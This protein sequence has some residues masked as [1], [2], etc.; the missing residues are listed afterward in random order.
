MLDVVAAPQEQRYEDGVGPAQAV[1]GV[2]EER[3]VQ[4]DVAEADV[5][6]G[7]QVADPVQ[8]R[9][10]GAQGLRVAAAVGDDEQGG[11]VG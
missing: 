2:R 1:Q 8:E 3:P 6:A 11:R 10:D 5:E 9:Q 7:A 4:L